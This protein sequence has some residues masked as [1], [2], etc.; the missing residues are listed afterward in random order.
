MG[1]SDSSPRKWT[2]VIVDMS[3]YAYQPVD[4][5]VPVSS[6]GRHSDEVVFRLS[7]RLHAALERLAESESTSVSE[8]V[9]EA[10]A[11]RWGLE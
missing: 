7:P 1:Q 5:A 4:S 6:H 2:E 8:I 9:R 10:L 11:V 3:G